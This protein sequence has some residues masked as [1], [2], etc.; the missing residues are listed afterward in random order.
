[1]TEYLPLLIVGA[2]IGTFSLAFSIA[3][4]VLKKKT[5]NMRTGRHMTDRE[6][7][8][9]FWKYAAP[10]W[11]E[12]ITTRSPKKRQ[13]LPFRH[14]ARETESFLPMRDAATDTTP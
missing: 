14:S 11:K 7:I 1:M 10:F 13:S 9:K 2:M 3:F 4:F 8:R 6:I 12:V 5:E